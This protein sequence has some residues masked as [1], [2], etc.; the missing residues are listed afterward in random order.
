[1]KRVARHQPSTPNPIAC[2]HQ[3]YNEPMLDARMEEALEEA[4]VALNEWLYAEGIGLEVDPRGYEPHAAR[5]ASL[6]AEVMARTPQGVDHLFALDNWVDARRVAL[7]TEVEA[8]MDSALHVPS[9]ICSEGALTWRNWKA[10]EREAR[11]PAELQAGFDELAERSA[12]LVPLLAGRLGRMRADYEPYGTTPVHIFAEREGIPVD[13]L[14]RLLATFGAAGRDHFEALLDCI[15]REVFGRSAGPAELHALY[16]NRMYEPTAPL[17]AGPAPVE[18]VLR[19]LGAMGF[20]LARVSV[21]LENRP[22]KYPGAF[23]L[24]VRVPSDVRVSVRQASAHHLVDML[25]HEFGHA[26]HFSGIRPDLPFVDRYWIHSGTH[27]TFST[28]FERLLDDP[29]YLREQFGLDA[30]AARRVVEFGEFKS[31]L[32]GAWLG[33]AALTTL[34]TWLDGLTWDEVEARLA[35]HLLAFTGVHMP[36]AFARLEPF[37]AAA[38]IYPA[39]YVVAGLRASRWL[40]HLQRLGG[41]AWWQVPAAQADIRERVALGGQVRFPPEWLTVD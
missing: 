15:S 19:A 20:D 41:G 8:A 14:R 13:A 38:S 30:A 21:D 3:I 34:E 16:L 35:A 1:M 23:C 5:L 6:Y 26:A 4:T 25:Y 33:A 40:E 7:D 27:E 18:A 24:P 32:T 2:N 29:G 36:P 9:L 11:G 39:G 12:A 37:T 17:F 22:R 28:L 31:A 10:F